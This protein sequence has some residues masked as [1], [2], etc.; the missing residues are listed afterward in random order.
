MIGKTLCKEDVLYLSGPMS[1]LPLG[2]RDA[3]FG[4]AGTLEQLFGCKVLNPAR[5]PLGMTREWYMARALDDVGK[6]TAVVL[7]DGWQ[8]S[9][10]AKA[11]LAEAIA[12][13]RRIL[14]EQDLR[15]AMH[16][17][18]EELTGRGQEKEKETDK[19]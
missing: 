4:M 16:F 6:C 19:E 15:M 14:L 17:R 1:G 12:K 3:F 8:D 18:F 5:N 13:G 9:E 2:N 10:G 7:L 11:E